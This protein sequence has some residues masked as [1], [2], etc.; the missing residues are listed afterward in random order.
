MA[1]QRPSLHSPTTRAYGLRVWEGPLFN[2]E[3]SDCILLRNVQV[4]AEGRL[5]EDMVLLA[6]E[7][8]TP[9]A[10]TRAIED[11]GNIQTEEGTTPPLFMFSQQPVCECLKCTSLLSRK[12]R[13]MNKC[14]G[15]QQSLLKKQKIRV[16][17]TSTRRTPIGSSS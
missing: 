15:Q 3:Y 17:V 6:R 8:S 7:L 1:K 13:R 11:E 2:E 16:D 14:D 5:S 12:R 10:S 9:H 4:D